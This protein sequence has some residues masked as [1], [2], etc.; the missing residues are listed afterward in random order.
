MRGGSD[1]REVYL[2]IG[3]GES[4]IVADATAKAGMPFSAFRPAGEA[5]PV[6][7]PWTLAVVQG[8]PRLPAATGVERLGSWTAVGGDAEAFSGTAR[9]RA[10]FAQPSRQAEMWQLD[11]GRVAES[12]R[13]R[14]NGRA[15]AT[16]IGPS[17]RVQV[18]PAQLRAINTLEV[19][20][21]NLSANRVR[22]L[23]RRGVSWKK[24]YNVN[25]PARFPDNRGADGLFSA[26]KWEPLESGLVGPVVLSPLERVR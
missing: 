24:F 18:D 20:V 7:G 26:A 14:L 8:G 4:L 12:A 16:L 5:I 17:F 9:Y 6:A 21:T 22:D 23:D 19:D 15:L 10:T 13:V 11:L 1:A 25:F 3:A 2:Q